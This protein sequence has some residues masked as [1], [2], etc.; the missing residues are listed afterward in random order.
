M[1][2]GSYIRAVGEAGR[3]RAAQSASGED[4]HT[5]VD[6][7]Q[8][9]APVDD[10]VEDDFFD[11][12][13]VPSTRR[14]WILPALFVLLIAGWTGFFA[15]AIH[16]QVMA[17]ASV[18]DGIAWVGQWSLPVVLVL[19]V[20]LL[21]LRNS[22]REAARYTDAAAALSRES[23]RLETRLLVVN[24]ELSLAREFLQS[25][26][27]ALDALGR[28]ATERLSDHAGH[29]QSLISNNGQ[30]LDTIANV[31]FTARDN[32]E[33][34]R[35]DLPVIANSARDVASQIGNAGERANES[36]ENL[37]SGFDRLND[38]GSQS[39][40]RVVELCERIDGALCEFSQATERL[41]EV[42]GERFDALRRMGENFRT[43]LG[44]HEVEALAGLE[45][46]ISALR[47]EARESSEQIR[48]GQDRALAIW[49]AQNT[50]LRDRL[51]KIVAEVIR[52]DEQALEA[53]ND[54]LA[55]LISEAQNV[56][57]LL[58]E[59]DRQFAVKLDERQ[60]ALDDAEDAALARLSER[61]ARL[62]ADFGERRE[63]ELV[64]LATIEG[65]G[66]RLRDELDLLAGKIESIAERAKGAEETIGR[67]ADHLSGT[68]DGSREALEET[69]RSLSNLTDASVRLLELVR[70]SATH[71]REDLPAAIGDFET[72]L[73]QAH[74]RAA[75]LATMLSEAS[76]SGDR[77]SE[78]VGEAE[79]KSLSAATGLDEVTARIADTTSEQGKV[80]ANLHELLTAFDGRNRETI[81]TIRDDLTAALD[82]LQHRAQ[83]VLGTIE[84]GQADRIRHLA[85][86]MASQSGDAIDRAMADKLAAMIAEFEEGAQRASQA[87]R[88]AAVQLRDQL[89]KVNDLTSNLESRV[90]HARAQAEE[91]ANNG[92]SRRVALITESLNSNAIDI[93]KALS[94]EVTDT[95]WTAYLRGDRGIFTRR[96]VRLLDNSELR[97]IAELFD[98]DPDF[99]EHVSRY[100]H[101]FE[102]MLR[103][104]L[105]TRDGH[106][107][108]VTVLSSDMGKLYVA[109]AQAIQRLRD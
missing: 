85:E 102:S 64:H 25:E 92:F 91:Q 51:E 41:G 109:L 65:S 32:M 18:A 107:L 39:D 31:S 100:I 49:E 76:A 19:A 53:S 10:L 4:A 33:K 55:A 54:K 14:R 59:R 11:D 40:R 23:E 104:L 73:M 35:N 75:G 101:D 17:G 46:R 36:L 7:S 82:E 45:R 83:S 8:E 47:E 16:R 63:T 28:T 3:R 97:E 44:S 50:A 29:L 60:K 13:V 52:L 5:E 95:A 74:D 61:L 1:G 88:D 30:Q 12:D 48:D 42:A 79:A 108:G 43:E 71:S 24:R 34:L 89:A 69:A 38:A 2:N 87:S 15:W 72:R 98:A 68:V 66:E 80:L 56:D 103:M 77:L 20:W 26:T 81:A 84:D 37:A 105:S 93:G 62:D 21:V 58:A 106:A 96:A 70:A 57:R 27:R 78:T 22:T 9:E 94:T 67:S 86:A 6:D 99:R 90:A